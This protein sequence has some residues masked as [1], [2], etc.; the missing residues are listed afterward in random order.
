MS[1]KVKELMKDKDAKVSKASAGSTVKGLLNS[2]AKKGDLKT[3]KVKMKF[4][5]K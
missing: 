1:T 4:G 2:A 5:K 3:L